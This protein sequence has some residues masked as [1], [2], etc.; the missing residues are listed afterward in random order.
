M[1]NFYSWGLSI[2]IVEPIS[3]NKTKVRFLSYPIKIDKETRQ[4]IRDLIEVELEDQSVVKSVQEGIKS[5]Y[6]TRGRYS[7]KHEGGV[8]HF[9]TLL[10]KF[11]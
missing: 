8:H 10:S 5:R 2:N 11:I 3:K 9:H 6:Y 7:S 4:A 1:M